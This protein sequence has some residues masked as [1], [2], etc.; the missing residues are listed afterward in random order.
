MT[1]LHRARCFAA[2]LIVVLALA[3]SAPAARAADP[4]E[5]NVILSLTG[6]VAF[7][8]NEQQQA[9]KAIE[10][11]VNKTGG[12]HGRPLSF[13]IA[14]DQSNPQV[15]VQLARA[16]LAKN[17][18]LILGP[19]GPDTCA[20]LSP[21]VA[22]NGPLLYCMAPTAQ[23]QAGSYVFLTQ[24]SGESGMAV[25][26][27]YL[28]ERGLRR[29]AF[30]ASTDAAGQ[31]AERA[32]NAV[33]ARPENVSVQIV[34]RQHF[35]TTDLSVAAQ[36]AAIKAT[37]PDALIAWSAGT[38]AG[39]LFRGLHDAGLDLPTVTS[40]ANL[41]AIF[42]KNFGSI[43]PSNLYFNAVPYYGADVVTNPLTKSALATMTSALA[44]VNAKPDQIE[45]SAWD[46]A[47]L[48][49]DALRKLGPEATAAALHAYLVDLRG[50][51]G[52]NGPYDFTRFPQR[53]LGEDS[54]VVVRWDAAR[55][56]GVAVSRFGGA[57]LPVK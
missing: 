40:A 45:I 25:N 5:I 8:G 27:R 43:V 14:D 47:M 1:F 17:V 50:W 6:Y 29:I 23:A 7:V 51:V 28:R 56:G 44:T 54:V 52:V 20:A 30:I 15:T 49:I 36:A 42:F 46:P 18:P 55:A 26:V 41:N 19:T 12:I 13:V 10:G 11:Y 37:T 4:Y 38:A 53:G 35:G 3:A 48:A 22:Q 33:L 9:L 34:T 24:Y 32:L 16:L 21:L 39:T 31:D 2:I 57:P